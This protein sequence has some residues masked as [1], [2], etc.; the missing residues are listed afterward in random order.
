MCISRN[1]PNTTHCYH[2]PTD[3]YHRPVHVSAVLLLLYL[4]LGQEVHEPLETGVVPVDPE[5]VD[6]LQVEHVAHVL[7]GP[8]VVTVG[9]ADLGAPVPVHDGLEDGGEGCDTFMKMT[10][11]TVITQ[12]LLTN[13][14]AYQHGV[15]RPGDVAGGRPKRTVY[16]D[17][18]R[19]A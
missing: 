5:E 16:K 9:A 6:L 1:L 2:L 13:P 19:L 8:G 14:G 15:L 12:L 4:Q 18:Q 17:L 11:L 7:I 10:L 3:V